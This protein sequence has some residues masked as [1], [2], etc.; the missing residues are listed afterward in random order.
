M[1]SERVQVLGIAGSLRQ[2]SFNR[3][4]IRAAQE[5]APDGMAVQSF[6]FKGIPL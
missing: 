6:D 3:G 1:I 2:G 4:L 5:L